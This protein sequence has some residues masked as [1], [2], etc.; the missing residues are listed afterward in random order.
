MYVNSRKGGT[1]MDDGVRVDL[2]SDA[3][4]YM[5]MGVCMCIHT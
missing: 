4:M 5:S 3:P 1:D 2:R